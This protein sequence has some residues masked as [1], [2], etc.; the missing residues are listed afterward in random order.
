MFFYLLMHKKPRLFTPKNS[1]PLSYK[2]TV[3]GSPAIADLHDDLLPKK[4]GY[5]QYDDGSH[6][7]GDQL[8]DDAAQ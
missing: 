4:G 7:G 1:P 2:T 3:S 5:P 6:N 8:A